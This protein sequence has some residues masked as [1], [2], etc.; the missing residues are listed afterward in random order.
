MKLKL[1]KFICWISILLSV[2]LHELSGIKTKYCPHFQFDRKL[3][4]TLKC[5]LDNMNKIIQSE[6]GDRYC[7]NIYEN[8][9]SCSKSNDYIG[10]CFD[11][12]YRHELEI[13]AQWALDSIVSPSILPCRPLTPEKE[14]LALENMNIEQK[15]VHGIKNSSVL[16][17]LLIR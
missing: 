8:M 1:K 11:K 6:Y 14:K 3:Q 5:L 13:L 12:E 10:N 15:Y 9:F 17:G 16:C 7:Y 4:K 2:Q